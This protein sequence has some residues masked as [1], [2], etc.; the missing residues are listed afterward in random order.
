MQPQVF[1]PD[2]NH[3]P[4]DDDEAV[5]RPTIE[6]NHIKP[7]HLGR[8]RRAWGQYIFTVI[9]LIGLAVAGWFGY[10]WYKNIMATQ[11]QLK[12]SV[13]DLQRQ[14][15]ELKTAPQA[16]TQPSTSDQYKIEE[17][18]VEFTTS[19]L[20]NGL[21]YAYDQNTKTALFTTRSLGYQL[22]VDNKSDTAGLAAGVLGAVVILDKAPTTTT[23]TPPEKVATLS[24]GKIVYY[25][26]PQNMPTQNPTTKSEIIKIQT[27]FKKALATTTLTK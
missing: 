6:P 4:P 19:D 23:G 5:T 15:S 18:G 24:D 16:S 21:E 27:E 8:P 25:V 13:A 12:A 7:N 26:S 10:R 1:H 3:T 14:N 11:T 17:L 22:A 2:S 20:L 9:V